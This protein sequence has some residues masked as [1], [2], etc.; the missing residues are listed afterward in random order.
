M[1][2]LEKYFIG[3]LLILEMRRLEWLYR[4]VPQS[5]A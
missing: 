1:G 4:I 3:E 5:A 2:Q